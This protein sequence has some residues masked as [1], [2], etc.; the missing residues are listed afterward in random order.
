M[1]TH[2]AAEIARHPAPA[3]DPALLM[4]SAGIVPDPWQAGFLEG[5]AENAAAYQPQA[6]C[7]ARHCS[8]VG[9]KRK[10]SHASMSAITRSS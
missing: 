8:R 10:P 4:E 1:T 5:I 6:R 9:T 2:T 7:S 3:L